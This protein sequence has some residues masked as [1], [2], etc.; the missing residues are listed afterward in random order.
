MWFR[1]SSPPTS[2]AVGAC[3]VSREFAS[4]PNCC[5]AVS[6]F[7]RVCGRTVSGFAG[8]PAQPEL[9][10]DRVWFR[11]G[12][13]GEAQRDSGRDNERESE[14][15]SEGGARARAGRERGRG[16]SEGGARAS[17]IASATARASAGESA[18]SSVRAGR[19]CEQARERGRVRELGRAREHGPDRV[20]SRYDTSYD[21][22][23]VRV[24]RMCR[25]PHSF[26]V[27][28]RQRVQPFV[29][30]KHSRALPL[31]SDGDNTDAEC[32]IRL[33]AAVRQRH[34]VVFRMRCNE[35]VGNLA[36][37]AL[38]T[39][40]LLRR[41]QHARLRYTPGTRMYRTQLRWG[42]IDCMLKSRCLTSNTQCVN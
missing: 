35:T 40:A 21:H 22:A 28:Q 9:L 6:G 18:S 31:P 5:R 13:E 42:W 41:R 38:Q 25:V 34:V 20:P 24:C 14:C 10:W 26:A 1:A 17:A 32:S 23:R 29:L 16:E 3:L 15:E 33:P 27:A 37:G 7:A 4:S 36:A 19:A 30:A 12:R 8:V 11:R 2:I 39:R